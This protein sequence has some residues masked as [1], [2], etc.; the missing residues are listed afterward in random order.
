MAIARL[1]SGVDN[2]SGQQNE[3]NV[4]LATPGTLNSTDTITGTQSATFADT[5]V[6]TAG[7]AI[8]AAQFGGVTN[9][10]ALQLSDSGNTATLT[11]GLVAGAARATFAVV[12]GGGND[13]VDASS[14]TNGTRIAFY[15]GS[16]SDNFTGGNGNDY[17]E[18][19]AVDLSGD[20]VAG[21]AGFDCL[22]LTTGGVVASGAIA[23]VSGI[24]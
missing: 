10:E 12:G 16:G 4:F 13:A 3:N 17:F 24:D 7:G 5:L 9:I 1:T 23:H 14:V 8:T 15:A 6:L 2:F 20:T 19:A 21:G 11:N 18:F 22:A